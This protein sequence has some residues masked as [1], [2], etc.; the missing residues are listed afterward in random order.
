MI[1]FLNSSSLKVEEA[2]KAL[3]QHFISTNKDIGVSLEIPQQKKEVKI[4]LKKVYR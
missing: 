1:R 2:Y 4:S 3:S